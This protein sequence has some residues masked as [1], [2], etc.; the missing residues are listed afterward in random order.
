MT[1]EQAFDL[2][3]LLVKSYKSV[4]IEV[5][6]VQIYTA[7][8]VDLDFE[9]CKAAVYNL[10]AESEFFPTIASIRKA[11]VKTIT[12]LPS[13]SEA[14]AEVKRE[15]GRTG[16]MGQPSFSCPQ[17]KQAVQGMGGWRTLCSMPDDEWVRK[18]FI[19]AYESYS[20]RAFA[21]AL[22]TPVARQLEQQAQARLLEPAKVEEPE[23]IFSI[24]DYKQ[25]LR[26]RGFPDK[27][28]QQGAT[29]G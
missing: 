5:E 10:I 24:E 15:F 23:K 18:D 19:K 20:E 6:T 26:D 29:H 28:L 1:S 8:I 21:E 25:M 13:G 12:K 9:A 4:K 11:A 22:H 27:S 7:M 14:W 2:V 3:S 16:Y 17:I